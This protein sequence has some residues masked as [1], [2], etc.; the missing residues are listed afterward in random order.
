MLEEASPFKSYGTTSEPDALLRSRYPPK[1]PDDR[2]GIRVFAEFCR[3][4]TRST[5]FLTSAGDGERAFGS[6]KLNR[7]ADN[8]RSSIL[9][10]FEDTQ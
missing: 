4:F 6:F 3:S 2:T 5:Q 10:P 8:C 7:L 9:N 1:L